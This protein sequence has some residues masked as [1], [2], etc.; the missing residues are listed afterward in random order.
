MRRS[1]G[2]GGEAYQLYECS[3]VQFL[4][5]GPVPTSHISLSASDI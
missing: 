2:W 3:K 4:P 5:K 1:P